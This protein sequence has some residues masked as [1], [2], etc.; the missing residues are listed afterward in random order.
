MSKQRGYEIR[1]RKGA[2]AGLCFY[3]ATADAYCWD[4]VIP[5]VQGGTDDDA[6]LIPA[7]ES[8]NNSKGGRTATEWLDSLIRRAAFHDS[9]CTRSCRCC[10]V[11]ADKPGS[12]PTPL[13]PSQRTVISRWQFI[14]Q[15]ERIAAA[16]TARGLTT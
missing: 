15:A 4:H 3:C 7:C 5:I 9:E 11:A 2:P 8:C 14:I 13:T 1:K 6:N 16:D 12:W 10:L